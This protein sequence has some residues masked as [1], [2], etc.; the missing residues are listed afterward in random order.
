MNQAKDIL[1]SMAVSTAGQTG[2]KGSGDEAAGGL[3]SMLTFIMSDNEAM[4]SKVKDTEARE[5]ADF[6]ET[7]H[8]ME[9][10]MRRTESDIDF[11]KKEKQQHE[12]SALT[13][14]MDMQ[15]ENRKLDK[16]NNYYEKLKPPCVVPDVSH[17]DRMAAR[18][19]EIKSLK[20]ALAILTG[21]E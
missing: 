17:E 5:Q 2:G 8:Q 11:K 3:M 14:K 21:E 4:I 19:Q 16:S 10:E 15:D 20:E 6:E 18:A 13:A 1:E 9:K 12:E 7:M